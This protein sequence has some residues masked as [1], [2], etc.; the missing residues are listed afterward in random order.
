MA[1]KRV[2]FFSTLDE[3]LVML[4][5]VVKALNLS[6]FLY[7]GGSSAAIQQADC[8]SMAQQIQAFGASRLYL[9]AAESVMSEINPKNLEPGRL[10]LI[11]VILPRE[12]GRVLF[13]SEVAVKTDWTD[14]VTGERFENRQLLSLFKGVKKEILKDMM[15]PVL[16]VNI[17]TGA[18]SID[19][20]V[21]YTNTARA[22]FE[23]GGE[24]MQEGVSNI[25]FR[26]VAEGTK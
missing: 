3:L 18:S 15:E 10:G 20:T 23:G 13:M 16:G 24:L 7:R 25:R 5:R 19:S 22:F 26:P 21:K 12:S 14:R 2:Q 4:C 1:T 8:E 9:A 11:Q 6:V 17:V